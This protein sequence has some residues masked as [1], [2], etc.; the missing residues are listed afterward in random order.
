MKKDSWLHQNH[1][2][3][4]CWGIV[5]GILTIVFLFSTAHFFVGNHDWQYFHY[6]MPIDAGFREGRLVQFVPT[7]FLTH[8]QVIP[9]LNAVLGFAFYA[10][11]AVF[12]A[13]WYGLEQKYVYVLL[14]SFLVVLHPL[15][16]TQFFYAYLF[17]SFA[18]WRFF[19]VLGV[20]YLWQYIHSKHGKYFLGACF[21]LLVALNGY[22]VCFE[23]ILV[24]FIGKFLIDLVT[25]KEVNI[26]FFKTYF[27]FVF[28][29]GIILCMDMLILALCKKY[30]LVDAHMY[31]TQFL[32]VKDV[33]YRF[34]G[35][36]QQPFRVLLFE[37][38]YCGKA[39]NWG[40]V[41]LIF[42]YLLECFFIKDMRRFLWAVIGI[43]ALLYG[44]LVAAYLSPY[45]IFF[46][47]RVN[48]Y[49]IPYVAAIMFVGIIVNIKCRLFVKNFTFLLG[50][51]LICCFIKGN[52]IAEKIWYLGDVQDRRAAD[53]V[54]NDLQP[55]LQPNHH[56]RL[57]TMG[58]LYGHRKFAGQS[59]TAFYNDSYWEYWEGPFFPNIFF[60][61]GLFAYEPSNPIWGD[62]I[63]LGGEAI[64]YDV[65]NESVKIEES[66]Y[67][68]VYARSFG[69]DKDILGQQ[70]K[71]LQA[72]PRKNYWAIG[73]KDIFLMFDISDRHK[74]ILQ[75]N[76]EHKS[77]F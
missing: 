76:V 15:I 35:N 18:L 31:N 75:W 19:S 13:K 28:A 23:L 22:A 44:I 43:I 47:L 70:L 50:M 27:S 9:I 53:R 74:N 64:F 16:C 29:L 14:F 17:L 68:R 21:C 51:L 58:G 11:S 66:I 37:I 69:K 42:I 33:Y 56:Y 5:F 65:I 52:L 59:L 30:N 49:S 26:K 67:A 6:G 7:W 72:Y 20:I 39:L 40:I 71:N 10:G 46:V 77:S 55:R 32:G 25:T 61:A 60:S 54:V 38:P 57:A 41:G 73:E 4:N 12:L 3:L 63:Y 48:S 1:F 45:Y 2:W 24:I 36:W 8:G 62:I 34:L